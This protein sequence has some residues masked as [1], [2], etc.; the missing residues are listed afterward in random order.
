MGSRLSGGWSP[1]SAAFSQLQWV[2]PVS[3]VFERL[4]RGGY[5]GSGWL[6]SSCLWVQSPAIETDPEILP[7]FETA[8]MHEVFRMNQI[9][10]KKVMHFSKSC[11]M[12]SLKASEILDN[13]CRPASCQLFL[14]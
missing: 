8:K 9:V 3:P 6:K 13:S 12:S 7:C 4:S 11:S 10:K 5:L 2:L 14:E 1:P